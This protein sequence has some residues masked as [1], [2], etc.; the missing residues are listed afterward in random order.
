MRICLVRTIPA[1][2]FRLSIRL[3]LPAAILA[4]LAAAQDLASL[5]KADRESPS[6]A[7]RSRIQHVAAAHP[8][9]QTGA[10]ARFALGVTSFEQKDY[11]R[12]SSERLT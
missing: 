5:V 4:S 11:D 2:L 1:L 10:L 3:A 8:A 12:A 6:V 7:R 9:D